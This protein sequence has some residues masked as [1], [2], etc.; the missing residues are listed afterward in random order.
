MDD[1]GYEVLGDEPPKKA[2]P[3]LARPVAKPVSKPEPPADEEDGG[4]EVLAAPPAKRPQ[5]APP[6]RRGSEEFEAGET[7]VP[8]EF[9]TKKVKDS[10]RPLKATDKAA[11]RGYGLFVL[12][13]GVCFVVGFFFLTTAPRKVFM[14]LGA[15]GAG[16]IWSG[17]GLILFP[18]PPEA[19]RAFKDDGGL[20]AMFRLSPPVWKVWFGLTIV[21][22]ALA[23][24]FVSS[25]IVPVEPGRR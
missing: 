19:L 16:C 20:M 6:R 5:L 8:F 15:G 9:R 23:A 22:M 4:Y 14:L 17:L 24:V 2:K 18:L 3:V 12:A 10:R 21:V 7:D 13:L 1:G 11:S 25:Q